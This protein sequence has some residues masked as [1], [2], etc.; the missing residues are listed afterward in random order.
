FRFLR[1]IG[2]LYPLRWVFKA[3]TPIIKTRLCGNN[4]SIMLLDIYKLSLLAKI[5]SPKWK[6]IEQ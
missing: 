3:L 4:P 6:N 5:Y 1:H 2:M